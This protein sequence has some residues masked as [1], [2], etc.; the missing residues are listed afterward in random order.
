MNNLCRTD[1][2]KTTCVGRALCTGHRSVVPGVVQVM[3]TGRTRRCP[4]PQIDRWPTRFGLHA[5]GINPLTDYVRFLLGTI[6]RLG[7][8]EVKGTEGYVMCIFMYADDF[9]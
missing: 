1:S 3:E 8:F 4:A 9:F 5:I 6:E 7:R 2:R